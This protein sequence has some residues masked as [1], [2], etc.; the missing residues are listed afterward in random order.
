VA[1]F[2]KYLRVVWTHA[3][4]SA[5]RLL[6]S[7]TTRW[8]QTFLAGLG[9]ATVIFFLLVPLL[10]DRRIDLGEHLGEKAIVTAVSAFIFT[11][12]AVTVLTVL[13]ALAYSPFAVW[14]TER[15]TAQ[16][17]LEAVSADPAKLRAAAAIA[18]EVMPLHQLLEQRFARCVN[19]WRQADGAG[20]YLSLAIYVCPQTL[21]MKQR[22]SAK[23][24]RQLVCVFVNPSS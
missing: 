13:F 6:G 22:L 21:T 5:W 17:T 14:R 2:L 20:L 10:R 1:E 19:G 11:P 23:R 15:R 7:S 3:W 12:L 16:H 9:A 4:H 18:R 24:L 8:A